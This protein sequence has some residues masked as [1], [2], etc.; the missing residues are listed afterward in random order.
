MEISDYSS[1]NG[2]E[3]IETAENLSPICNLLYTGEKYAANRVYSGP[4]YENIMCAFFA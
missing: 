2:R 3:I 4:C 1:V